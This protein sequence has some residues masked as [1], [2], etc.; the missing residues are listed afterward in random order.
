[1]RII[2]FSWT[3][4]ALR[5]RRK[6]CTRRSW[7]D[8]YARSWRAGEYSAAYDRGARVGGHQV[9]IVRLVIKPYVEH[10][11]SMNEDDYEAE[12]LRW[13]EQQGLLIKGQKP[14][15]F[16]DAW[17]EADERVYVVRFEIISLERISLTLPLWPET[18]HSL[19]RG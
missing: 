10:T 4:P 8:A 13:M 6:T 7:D 19:L 18:S 12:G 9:G 3:L 15:E 1:M 5:A 2:S 17:R 14:R 16:F 11:R